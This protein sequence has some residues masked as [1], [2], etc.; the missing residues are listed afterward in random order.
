MVIFHSYVNVY[1]PV[2]KGMAIGNP[3]GNPVFS[4]VDAFGEKIIHK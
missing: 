3:Y 1:H 2:I 4:V